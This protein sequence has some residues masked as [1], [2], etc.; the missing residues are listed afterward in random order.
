MSPHMSIGS[1]EELAAAIASLH[2]PESFVEF[3][4]LNQEFLT[5]DA[6]G[7]AELKD[8]KRKKEVNII[9]GILKQHAPEYCD[10]LVPFCNTLGRLDADLFQPVLHSVLLYTRLCEAQ[11]DNIE[12]ARNNIFLQIVLALFEKVRRDYVA[13]FDDDIQALVQHQPS[14]EESAWLARYSLAYIIIS[15]FTAPA[16][17]DRPIAEGSKSYRHFFD[18]MFLTCH[19]KIGQTVTPTSRTA[20]SKE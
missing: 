19:N 17:W 12:Q 1:D 18:G 15:H 20:T 9:Y 6:A 8:E 14:K 2:Q 10:M 16:I 7:F 3:C 13:Q 4:K 5:N 11:D